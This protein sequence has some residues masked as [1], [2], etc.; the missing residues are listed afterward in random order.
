MRTSSRCVMGLA[1]DQ[2]AGS[3]EK[4]LRKQLEQELS[5]D[6][7]SHKALIRGEVSAIVESM[8]CSMQWCWCSNFWRCL[9]QI[10]QYLESQQGDAEVKAEQEENRE[11]ESGAEEEEEEEPEP[12]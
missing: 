7:S 9:L 10:E 5:R 11:E 8:L 4:Q 6:L 2:A 1:T 3:A 12:K